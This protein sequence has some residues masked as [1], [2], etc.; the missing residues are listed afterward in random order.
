MAESVPG[1]W[2]ARGEQPCA[3]RGELVVISGDGKGVPMRTGADPSPVLVSS[4]RKGPK[5]DGKKMAIVGAVYNVDP[6][7]NSQ[8]KHEPTGHQQ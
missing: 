6:W 4:A 2:E 3:T 1:F 8:R 7:R 5:P